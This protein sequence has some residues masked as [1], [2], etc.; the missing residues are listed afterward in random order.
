MFFFFCK[1]KHKYIQINIYFSNFEKILRIVK[2]TANRKS[3]ISMHLKKIKN[4]KVRQYTDMQKSWKRTI[5]NF[6]FI[7]LE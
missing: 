4:P 5:F 7:V 1:T 3:K 2:I 6:F